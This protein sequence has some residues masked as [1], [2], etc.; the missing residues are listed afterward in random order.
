MW[1]GSTLA[2]HSGAI[3]AGA[4]VLC[5]SFA[6]HVAV[7]GQLVGWIWKPA[8]LGFGDDESWGNHLQGGEQIQ[9]LFP[10]LTLADPARCCHIQCLDLNQNFQ[11]IR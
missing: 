2:L 5:S 4:A 1:S 6:Y 7:R 3:E 9:P 11:L 10:T 8:E